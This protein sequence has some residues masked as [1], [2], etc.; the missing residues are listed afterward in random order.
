MKAQFAAFL[1]A[2]AVIAGGATL[3]AQGPAPGDIAAA[4]ALQS[5]LGDAP[6]WAIF[7][8]R[9]AKAP[10]VMATIAVGA[11]LAAASGGRRRLAAAP[12]AYAL[13]FVA[14]KALRLVVF[15]PRPDTELIAVA[16]ASASSGLPS[17]FGLVYGAIFGAAFWPAQRSA[18]GICASVA[19]AGLI[20][21][22]AAARIVLGGHWPSQMAASVA[23]GLLLARASIILISFRRHT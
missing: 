20:A 1:A 23:I 14:D 15:A 4:R 19:A 17:T 16:S 9:T 11:A 2:I 18:L 22:G 10:L 7:L 21:T 5:A 6:Q 12:V 3:L 13:A 8:T